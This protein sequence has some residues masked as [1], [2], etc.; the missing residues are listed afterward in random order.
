MLNKWILQLHGSVA[1]HPLGSS[2]QELLELDVL[3]YRA[4]FDH[5]VRFTWQAHT[6]TSRGY[7]WGDGAKHRQHFCPPLTAFN[8]N[9]FLKVV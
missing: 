7:L 2:L 5:R 6:I 8:Y 1:R 9:T 4:M 3:A